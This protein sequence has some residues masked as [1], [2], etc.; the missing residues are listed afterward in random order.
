MKYANALQFSA[1]NNNS[2]WFSEW[3]E[4]KI[5]YVNDSQSL[6]IDIE[7]DK[8]TVALRPG[9]SVEIK[10]T[11]DQVDTIL[12]NTN[13]LWTM[14]DSATI[15]ENGSLNGTGLTGQFSEESYTLDNDERKTISYILTASQDIQPGRYTLMLGSGN[16]ELTVMKAVEL[17]ILS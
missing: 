13:S 15:K 9:D 16:N 14:Q 3:S 2:I 8:E 11:V 5:G 6:P 10:I 7:I 17:N 12:G 4:N 1:N